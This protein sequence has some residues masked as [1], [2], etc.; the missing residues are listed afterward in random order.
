M[1]SSP[2]VNFALMSPVNVS[3]HTSYTVSVRVESARL[4]DLWAWLWVE[5][6]TALIG[7][8]LLAVVMQNGTMV[9]VHGS[10]R[11]EFDVGL[12]WMMGC[13]KEL[14]LLNCRSPLKEQYIISSC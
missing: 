4:K 14:I 9:W 2:G 10:R 13:Q 6:R 5:N 12:E 7:R 1:F 3:G 8:G 11:G